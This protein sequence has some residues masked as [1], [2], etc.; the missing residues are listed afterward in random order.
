MSVA[1]NND[2]NL[3]VLQ[4]VEMGQK[5]T[6]P[7]GRRIANMTLYQLDCKRFIWWNFASKIIRITEQYPYWGRSTSMHLPW[8]GGAP[9]IP[10]ERAAE[11][12]L[13]R[14]A[15]ISLTPMDKIRALGRTR[16]RGCRR[17]WKGGRRPWA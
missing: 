8:Y 11:V 3:A 15:K 16:G 13:G 5:A 17:N 1:A 9:W 10:G 14:L 7:E 6:F 4:L 12:K 2:Q